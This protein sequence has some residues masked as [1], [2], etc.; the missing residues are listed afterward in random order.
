MDKSYLPVLGFLIFFLVIIIG[1]VLF[2]SRQDQ[3]V[4]P[5]SSF[6]LTPSPSQSLTPSTFQ[7]EPITSWNVYENTESEFRVSYPSLWNKQEYE[8][9]DD[10]H[11]IRV[12]FSP[13]VLPCSTCSYH[14]DGYISILIYTKTTDPALYSLYQERLSKIGKVAGYQP[15]TVAGSNGVF[16]GNSIAFEH[17][18]YVFDFILDG[19]N[20]TI[21]PRKSEIFQKV[22]GSFEPINISFRK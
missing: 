7:E 6:S 20:R 19:N 16:S 8:S 13:S 3:Q 17:H 14:Q 21:D 9:P 4:K 1:I 12:A 2:I 5:L 11:I 22:V 18:G 15:V 10:K